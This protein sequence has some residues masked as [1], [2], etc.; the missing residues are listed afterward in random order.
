[1]KFTIDTEEI[2]KQNIP[3]ELVF[4]LL[5]LYCRCYNTDTGKQMAETENLVTQ[6]FKG[7]VINNNGLRMIQDLIIR[8]AKPQTRPDSEYED[9]A[10]ALI[11]IYPKGLKHA[12]GVYWTGSVPYIIQ[13][14][15]ILEYKANIHIDKDKAVKATKEYISSFSDYN[16]MQI[17][18]Y[19]ILKSHRNNDGNPW[20]SNLL[21][22]MEA[23]S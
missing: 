12:S 17:L 23:L 6:T 4:Y 15:K 5:P 8:S 3:L 21:S 14:L 22:A 19:F 2:K 9:I 7:D 18:P 20:T 10:K 16:F 13:K 11:D 1:M